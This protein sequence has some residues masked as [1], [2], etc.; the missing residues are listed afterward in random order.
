MSVVDIV[1]E[2]Q[3]GAGEEYIPRSGG[4]YI[5]QT[6]PINFNIHLLFSAYSNVK[7]VS[8]GLKYL[9]LVI[10]FFSPRITLT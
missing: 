2:E 8:E 5:T 7:Y 4:G 9:S 1:Q 6:Q 10:A 3:G